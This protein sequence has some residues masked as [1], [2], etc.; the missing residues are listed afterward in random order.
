VPVPW[1]L[2]KFVPEVLY[3]GDQFPRERW[4]SG[5]EGEVAGANGEEASR[6][7]FV[8]CRVATVQSTVIC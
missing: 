2:R 5:A 1:R 6:D 3:H 4:G 7:K 8:K